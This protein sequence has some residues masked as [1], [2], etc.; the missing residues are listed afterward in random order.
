MTDI[1]LHP[2]PF[3]DEDFATLQKLYK[4]FRPFRP[5]IPTGDEEYQGF[6]KLGGW[7]SPKVQKCLE[8]G[9]TVKSFE[10]GKRLETGKQQNPLDT[11]HIQGFF[12]FSRF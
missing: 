5:F 6:G 11:F 10:Y 4:T 3:L 9:K 12:S 8:T 7:Y 1:V 2:F